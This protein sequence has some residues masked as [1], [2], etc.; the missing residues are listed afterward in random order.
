M[1][2]T[3][4]PEKSFEQAI[5]RLEEIVQSLEGDAASLDESLTLYEEGKE[6]VGFC[7]GKLAVVEQK[8]KVLS[9]PQET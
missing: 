6:L 7:L 9:P 1:S 2:K 3:P 4:P 5:R 8:L